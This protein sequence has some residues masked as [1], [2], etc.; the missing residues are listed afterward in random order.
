MKEEKFGF[1]YIWF[2]KKNKRYYVGSHWGTFNDGYVCSSRWMRNS[3]K[4]R[5][6]DF[7]RRILST[8]DDRSKLLLEEFKWLSLIK[9]S[10]LGERYYNLQNNQFNHWS[11]TGDIKTVGQK[12]S[13]AKKGKPVTLS[14]EALVDRGNTIS[15]VKQENFKTRTAH[16]TVDMLRDDFHSGLI[17]KQVAAKYDVGLPTIRRIVSEAGYASLREIQPKKVVKHSEETRK[18]ISERMRGQQTPRII[19]APE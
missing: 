13:A 15:K 16:I 6:E 3:Y 7:R 5:P 14:E 10:E 4:R 2:D 19:T 12:I 17:L 18:K 11:N 1:I 9:K 8:I